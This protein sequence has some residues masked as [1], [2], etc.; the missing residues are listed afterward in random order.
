[1]IR[2]VRGHSGPVYDGPVYDVDPV[3]LLTR[4]VLRERTPALVAETCA[5][6]VGL[7]DVPHHVRRHGRVV[8]TGL[9]LGMRAAA[10]QQLS[11][12]EDLRLELGEPVAGSFADALGA[13]TADGSLQA[14]RF[15]AQ[16]LAPFVLETCVEAARRARDASPEAWAELLD[17]LGEDG[18][19]L[20]AVVRAAEWDA[21]LRT[22]AEQLVLAAV[23]H[24]PLVQ[25]EAEGLPLSLV[26]AAEAETRRA[27][28]AAIEPLPVLQ[29]EELAGA[30]FL[31]DVALASSGLEQPVPPDGAGRLLE[32]L[33]GEGLEPEE[34]LAVL[35]HLPVLADTA[36]AV[37][38]RL[39]GTS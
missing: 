8:P 13:L 23:G 28:G 15:D 29:D 21:P 36:D 11:V 22:D 12:D 9:T 37:D 31:A 18:D 3:A 20:A 19:D 27:A 4:E 14:D 5:W 17:D 6:S 32:V 2:T 26:R 30:R 16:V 38:R 7:S 25:L 34:V 24:A 39:R 1:V 10:A 35:P 33:L